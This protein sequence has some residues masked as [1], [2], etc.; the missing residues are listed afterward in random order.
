MNYN[1]EE[2]NN[3]LCDCEYLN[4]L[5]ESDYE[6]IWSFNTPKEKLDTYN[7]Y[8][9]ERQWNLKTQKDYFKY[10]L[11]LAKDNLI[12]EIDFFQ[13]NLPYLNT[14][15]HN[16]QYEYCKSKILNMNNN[17]EFLSKFITKLF[18]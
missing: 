6:H 17:S 7:K 2:F 15:K 10:L 18:N 13:N 12:N 5:S 3:I 1:I 9:L 8:F 16:K 11:N 4:L 14:D